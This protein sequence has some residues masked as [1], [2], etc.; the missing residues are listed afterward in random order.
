MVSARNGDIDPVL[1]DPAGLYFLDTRFLSK[2]VLM[3][4]GER[5]TPL[6]ID[7]LQ[8]FEARFFLV[9]GEPTHYVSATLSVIRHRTIAAGLDEEISVLN[10]SMRPAELTIR[11]DVASDFAD[12]SDIDEPGGPVDAT[13]GRKGRC[14]HQ[15]SEGE[16]WLRYEREKFHRATLIRSSE[17]A[18]IDQ[19][20]LTFRVRIGPHGSWSTRLHVVTDI[21]APGGEDVSGGGVRLIR[22]M[23]E[24]MREELDRWIARAPQLE[25]DFAPLAR[26][27]QRSLVDLA[28]LRNPGLDSGGKIPSAGLPWLNTVIGRQSIFTSIQ[29]LPYLPELAATTLQVLAAFQSTKLD[30]FREEQPGKI[31]HLL[32]LNESAAFEERPYARYYGSVDS[33]PLFVVLLDEY[34]RWTGDAELVHRLEKEARAALRWIDEW[35]A[36]VGDGYLWY[37]RPRVRGEQPNQCWKESEAAICYADGRLPG[38]PRATCEVQGYVY[39][40]KLCGAR[41]ARTFWD[42]PAYADRLER[43]AAE[44]RHRFNQDFWLPDRRYYAIAREADGSLVDAL[45]S[46]LGHLLWSGIVEPDRAGV[47][48]EH[49]LGPGLFTGWGVRTL[50]EGQAAYNPVG[51][52]VGAVWPYDNSIIADGMRRYGFAT[53]AAAVAQAM[54]EAAR[55]FDGRLPEAFA[56]YHRDLTAFPVR[57]P[58]ATS[59]QGWS[60][61]AILLLLRTVL[62]LHP[63]ADHLVV[64]ATVPPR[65]GQISLFGICGRWGRSD[66]VGRPGGPGSNC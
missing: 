28:A 45:T 29:A 25:C 14:S 7:D 12:I 20:G 19:D 62:G 38:F 24:G 50:A 48:V 41:L 52:H 60:A 4:D 36:L 10:H 44:L 31:L 51:Y 16:L 42:D 32:R 17:P 3:V 23:K 33:T 18:G 11:L 13:Q 34:E 27:Y 57:Y 2:W 49:L 61:G 15:I 9:P 53:E 64:R 54:F 35:G 8:Y 30:D 46:N 1:G 37:Q 40:A 26:A 39:N 63:H 47:L 65:L 55:Y 5:L 66:A 6:S 22:E 58:S 21:R 43:E 56:G 59:P